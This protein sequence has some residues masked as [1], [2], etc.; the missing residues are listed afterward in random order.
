[1]GVLSLLLTRQNVAIIG[2]VASVL[3]VVTGVGIDI[4]VMLSLGVVLAVLSLIGGGLLGT[5]VALRKELHQFRE[6]LRQR[7]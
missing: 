7:T 4:D 3:L 6:E 5:V 1:M 2:L